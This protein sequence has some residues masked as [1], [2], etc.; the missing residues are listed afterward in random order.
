MCTRAYA[1]WLPILVCAYLPVCV[2]VRHGAPFSANKVTL[3][4]L[5]ASTSE[6]PRDA[7][8][9]PPYPSRAPTNLPGRGQTAMES[10]A[11]LRTHLSVPLST[12]ALGTTPQLR[13]KAQ[14]CSKRS[15]ERSQDT[16]SGFWPAE[17]TKKKAT[18]GRLATKSPFE[19]NVRGLNV[20]KATAA[21]NGE[22]MRRPLRAKRDPQ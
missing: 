7:F 6:C 3:T 10:E 9:P 11:L 22:H 16:N 4:A 18:R 13:K 5:Q 19:R 2:S 15:V 20:D 21:A 12:N 1:T 8:V 17:K 14:L